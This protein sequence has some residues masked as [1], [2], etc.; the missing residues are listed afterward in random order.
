M[1]EKISKI[2]DKELVTVILLLVLTISLGYSFFKLDFYTKEN[3]SLKAELKRAK[4]TQQKIYVEKPVNYICEEH[5]E[6]NI[7]D[8]CTNYVQDYISDNKEDI[9]QEDRDYLEYVNPRY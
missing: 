6:N 7:E 5:I 9:C 8:I 1:K 3:I 2:L 4:E